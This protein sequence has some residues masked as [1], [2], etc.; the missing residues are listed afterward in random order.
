[1]MMELRKKEHD[2]SV[3]LRKTVKVA[4]SRCARVPD[5]RILES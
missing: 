4:E 1:M 5:F 2:P 3:D